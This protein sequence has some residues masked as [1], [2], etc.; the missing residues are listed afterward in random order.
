MLN[1]IDQLTE[2]PTTIPPILQTCQLPSTANM[3]TPL[4]VTNGPENVIC[5]S[6]ADR[7]GCQYCCLAFTVTQTMAVAVGCTSVSVSPDCGCETTVIICICISRPYEV[8]YKTGC[9]G[10]TSLVLAHHEPGS[11]FTILIWHFHYCFGIFPI[12]ICYCVLQAKKQLLQELP[13]L[14]ST[15]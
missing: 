5:S 15:R 3:P 7:S 6:L 13:C 1:G 4:P 10:H 11:I 14:P 12:I 2:P 8:M 9:S